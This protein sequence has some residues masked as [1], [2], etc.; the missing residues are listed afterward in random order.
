MIMYG[1]VYESASGIITRKYTK[2]GDTLSIL[3]SMFKLSRPTSGLYESAG[4]FR[5]MLSEKNRVFFDNKA[6]T[7]CHVQGSVL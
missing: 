1:K 4:L 3:P 7:T 5:K 2:H 6:L